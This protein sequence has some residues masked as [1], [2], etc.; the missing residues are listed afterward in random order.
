MQL[1]KLLFLVLIIGCNQTPPTPAPTVSAPEIPTPITVVMQDVLQ[2]PQPKADGQYV[3]ATLPC[4]CGDFLV[5]IPSSCPCFDKENYPDLAAALNNVYTWKKTHNNSGGKKVVG[6][7]ELLTLQCGCTLQVYI[8]GS[9]GCLG[10][11]YPDLEKY[12]K[13]V[14]NIAK[15][16]EDVK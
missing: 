12:L 16:H 11:L 5:Y 2:Q 6:K 10:R 4:K 15:K 13:E 3:T 14:Y 8:P 9:S 1:K 7:Y